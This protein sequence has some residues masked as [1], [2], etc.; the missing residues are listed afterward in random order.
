M[1][2]KRAIMGQKIYYLAR[3][4]RSNASQLGLLIKVSVHLTI[5]FPISNRFYF[6]ISISRS[7][8]VNIYSIRYLPISKCGRIYRTKFNTCIGHDDRVH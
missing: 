2:S 1:R 4:L 5:S 8:R 6:D 7:R 3:T